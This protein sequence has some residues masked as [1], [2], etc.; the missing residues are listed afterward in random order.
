MLDEILLERYNKLPEWLRWI[1]FL[2]LSFILSFILGVSVDFIGKWIGGSTTILSILVSV[3][4]DVSFLVLIFDTV[5]RGKLKWVLSLI[6]IY[7][8]RVAFLIIEL[9]FI[10]SM[11][12]LSYNQL[13][14][15]GLIS[16]VI[17]LVVSITLFIKSKFF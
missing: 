5:P 17:I 6:I 2:P 4:S 14:F 11:R 12:N 1:I 8:L 3:I 13:F 16:G 9:I 15:R 7:S 10:P